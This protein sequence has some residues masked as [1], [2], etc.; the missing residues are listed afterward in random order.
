MAVKVSTM[1]SR[2]SSLLRSGDSIS[3]LYS[4]QN[5]DIQLLSREIERYSG[6]KRTATSTWSTSAINGFVFHW[7]SPTCIIYIV[8]K[9]DEVNKL[10]DIRDR[11]TSDRFKGVYSC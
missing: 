8:T 9:E 5:F 2:D 6:R 1:K 3:Y 11:I 10:L 7:R 4:G